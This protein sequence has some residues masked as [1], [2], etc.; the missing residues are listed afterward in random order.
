ME[1]VCG[2]E[3]IEGKKALK[4]ERRDYVH[5][6]DLLHTRSKEPMP[7]PSSFQRAVLTLLVLNT[8]RCD[9]PCPAWP[10]VA[11]VAS[12]AVSDRVLWG[13]ATCSRC[14]YDAWR[15]GGLAA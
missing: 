10:G 12:A 11:A 5:R 8:A 2:D 1:D 6:L 15:P 3:T 14:A 7:R 13:R 4:N 9:T